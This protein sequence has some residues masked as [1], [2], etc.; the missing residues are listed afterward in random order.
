MD[1]AYS[2]EYETYRDEVRSF[3]EKHRDKAP[4]ARTEGRMSAQEWQQLLIQ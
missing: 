2:H 3:L 1:L 4:R